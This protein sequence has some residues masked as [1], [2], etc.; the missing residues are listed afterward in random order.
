[1]LNTTALTCWISC[2][3]CTP[4]LRS[5]LSNSTNA[6]LDNLNGAT[7]HLYRRRRAPALTSW[8]AIIKGAQ[9]GNQAGYVL[10]T[11]KRSWSVWHD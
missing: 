3:R 1:M 2:F 10:L 11:A 9:V 4:L 8:A 5:K 6:M 7:L